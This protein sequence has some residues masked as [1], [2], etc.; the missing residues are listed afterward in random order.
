MCKHA[1]WSS[2]KILLVVTKPAKFFDIGELKI[3]GQ[4]QGT[5]SPASDQVAPRVSLEDGN[6]LRDF[7][8]CPFS[9]V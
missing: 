8:S 1:H 7:W 2:R 4:S 6:L 3:Q 5:D 9:S